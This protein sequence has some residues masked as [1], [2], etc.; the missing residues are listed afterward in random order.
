MNKQP[1]ISKAAELFLECAYTGDGKY[2]VTERGSRHYRKTL[3][4][5][6]QAFYPDCVEELS[7]GN[8]APRGGRTG[9]FV[10]VK[11]TPEFYEKFGPWMEWKKQRE[12]EIAAERAAR[13]KEIEAIGDQAKLLREVFI[14]RPDR[15][16]RV[17]DRIKNSPSNSRRSGNW[18]G[19][20]RMKAAKWVAN[21]RFDLLTLSAPDIRDIAFDMEA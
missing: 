15:L 14:E 9:D 5:T 11:F 12:A 1:K 20:V 8:D 10:I 3:F 21:G 2:Y 4:G 17:L 19:W 16:E 13:Q 18:R 6:F 7:W